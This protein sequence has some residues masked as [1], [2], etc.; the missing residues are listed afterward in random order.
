MKK[1][2]KICTN[3]DRWI[4]IHNIIIIVMNIVHVKKNPIKKQVYK[5]KCWKK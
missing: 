3:L 2:I 4:K 1:E 5:K